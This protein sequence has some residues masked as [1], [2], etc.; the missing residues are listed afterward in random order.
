MGERKRY[1]GLEVLL[2]LDS[3]FAASPTSSAALASTEESFSLL[4]LWSPWSSSPLDLP[5]GEYTENVSWMGYVL[6]D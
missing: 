2:L 3:L 5:G 1:F 6:A 4:L